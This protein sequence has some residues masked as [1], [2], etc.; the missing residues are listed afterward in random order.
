MDFAVRQLGETRIIDRM[1]VDAKR[2]RELDDLTGA[3][4]MARRRDVNRL[5]AFG[6]LREPRGDSMES[7]QI[8][9]GSHERF[10][11]AMVLTARSFGPGWV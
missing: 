7:D 6:A 10:V 3:T 11:A 4:I 8:A 5:H 9:R 2:L 1:N